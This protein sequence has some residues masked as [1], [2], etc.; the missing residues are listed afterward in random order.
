MTH[1]EFERRMPPCS[2]TG[3][4]ALRQV[5]AAIGYQLCDLEA[6]VKESMAG[7]A[8]AVKDSQH[9]GPKP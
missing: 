1:E 7:V 8:Q 2:D 4:Y 3:E 6:A 9:V 5:I